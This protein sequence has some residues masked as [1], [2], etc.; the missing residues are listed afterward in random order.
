MKN[1]MMVMFEYVCGTC[2][3]FIICN[4]VDHCKALYM[5]LCEKGRL[6]K[7]RCVA[8]LEQRETTALDTEMPCTQQGAQ[9]QR[10]ESVVMPL[11][12]M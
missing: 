3:F 1:E 11:L 7:L 2:L 9:Q 12:C 8:H 6:E 4:V 10:P 5:T